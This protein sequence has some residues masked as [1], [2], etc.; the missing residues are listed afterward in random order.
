MKN[1]KIVFLG[2]TGTVGGYAVPEL[3]AAGFDVVAVGR[4]E[5]DGGFFASCG[6]PYVS[7]DISV[8][9]DF[10]KLPREGVAAV[11]NLAGAVPARMK[12]YDPQAYVDSIVT[13]ALN[14]LEYAR[15]CGAD[16]I[17][18]AQSVADVIHLYGSRT[19][20]DADSP[21]KFPL[22]GDHAVYSI[23]KN[24]AVDLIEHYHA[25]FGLKRFILRFPNIYLYHPNP[26]YFLDGELR[27][28]SYRLMIERAKKGEPLEI[29][30]DPGAMRDMVYVKDCVQIIEKSLTAPVEGGIYNVGTGIGTS[31]KEQVEGIVEVFSPEGRKSPVIPRPDKPSGAEYIMDISKTVRDLGYSP[32]YGYRDYL[33]DM[34]KEME[35][36]RFRPI[37]GEDK[38]YE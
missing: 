28:Q 21:R 1:G 3:A 25:A 16:R 8:K 29:W 10:G 33:K 5:S 14:S 13:G 38:E 2:A 30:G 17:V 37:W 18:F 6:V 7:M 22:T 11:V 20:I 35:L 24:A 34:K 26:K 27:Y 23:C 15:E 9:S 32:R 19:P 4:R 12:G 31:M 36:K